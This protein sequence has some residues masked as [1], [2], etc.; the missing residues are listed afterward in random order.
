LAAAVPT[1]ISH[2]IQNDM[3][4][5]RALLGRGR[6]REDEAE[7]KLKPYQVI[8]ANIREAQGFEGAG[9]SAARLIK[10]LKSGEWKTALPLVGGLVQAE[11]GGIPFSIYVTKTEGVPVRID[12]A[13]PA[14]IAFRYVKPETKYPYLTR[15][16]A[17]KLGITPN[18]VVGFA[19]LLGLRGHEDFH[20]SIKV[21]R[22][23]LVS[24]YSEKARDV[25]AAAVAKEGVDGLWAA[26]K[27]G[28]TRDPRDYL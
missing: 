10:N 8:E 23:G 28:E 16:L 4:A 5:V 6:R 14:A 11:P 12:P 26:A 22:T 15:E 18:K 7:A 3:E 2:V 21:S 17:E 13:A 25:I 24:R 19:K 9:P 1:D 27:A 20:T